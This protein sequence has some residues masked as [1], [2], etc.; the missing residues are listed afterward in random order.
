[1]TTWEYAQLHHYSERIVA[2]HRNVEQIDRLILHLPHG[3]T[4]EFGDTDPLAALNE[5]GADGWEAFTTEHVT[6]LQP[7]HLGFQ[8][9]QVP[10][11]RRYWLKRPKAANGPDH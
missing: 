1:M 3:E 11:Q 7:L 5:L 2:R 8:Q 6:A 10:I 9:A 4:Q